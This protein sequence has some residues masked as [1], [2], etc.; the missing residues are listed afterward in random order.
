MRY[1]VDQLR[2]EYYDSKEV[3]YFRRY[4]M[5]KGMIKRSVMHVKLKNDDT[6]LPGSDIRLKEE[7]RKRELQIQ[8]KY[9]FFCLWGIRKHKWLQ[10]SRFE[11]AREVKL[12]KVAVL[13]KH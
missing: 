12:K 8:G 13:N 5:M 11:C 7:W 2:R 10:T 4:N 9:L 6:P 3:D 1:I